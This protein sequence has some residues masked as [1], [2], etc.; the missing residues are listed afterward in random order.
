MATTNK[1]KVSYQ[2]QYYQLFI[3]IMVLI[4]GTTM[5]TNS[6]AWEAFGFWFPFTAVILGLLLVSGGGFATIIGLLLLMGGCSIFLHQLDIVTFPSLREI[7]GWFFTGIGVLLILAGSATILQK[8]KGKEVKDGD[9]GD[10]GV[11]Y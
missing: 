5:I 10:P 2:R 4:L 7:L 3:G 9:Q 11:N 8:W 1:D 6:F